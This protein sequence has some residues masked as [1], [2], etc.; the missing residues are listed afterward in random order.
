MD[1][2]EAGATM[3]RRGVITWNGTVTVTR[4]KLPDA[5][6]VLGNTA[7]VI[8]VQAY[9]TLEPGPPRP[10]M[11]FCWVPRTAAVSGDVP[12]VQGDPLHVWTLVARASS[13][14][15]WPTPLPT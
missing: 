13:R 15:A 10:G 1:E 14:A 4:T 12:S 2:M 3:L 8:S 9:W 11:R 6:L 7:S 5:Q